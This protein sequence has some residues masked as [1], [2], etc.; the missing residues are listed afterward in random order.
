MTEPEFSAALSSGAIKSEDSAATEPEGGAP[1]PVTQSYSLAQF[2]PILLQLQSTQSYLTA[3][4]TYVPQT[5]QEQIQFVYTGGKYYLYLYI[6][7]QW[8]SIA[9]SA[10]SMVFGTSGRFGGGGVVTVTN[11]AITT[12]SVIIFSRNFAGGTLGEINIF[13]QSA[14]SVT[15]SSSSST[16]TSSLNYLILNP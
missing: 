8:N 12:S 16:D 6:N 10:P 13:S 5:F 4:P 14:G 11:S 7:N 3:A 2:V 9:L 1:T 15:F